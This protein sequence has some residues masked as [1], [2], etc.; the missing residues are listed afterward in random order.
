MGLDTTLYL[1]LYHAHYTRMLGS[2]GQIF[3]CFAPSCHLAVH[4]RSVN[5]DQIN[6]QV[7]ICATI[8]SL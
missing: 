7:T 1:A 3:A 2:F 6:Q 8:E 5:I 4:E